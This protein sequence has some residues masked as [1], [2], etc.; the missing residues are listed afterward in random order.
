[1][2]RLDEMTPEEAGRAVG[3]FLKWRRGSAKDKK[4]HFCKG[5]RMFLNTVFRE[6]LFHPNP[7]EASF[8]LQ[9]LPGRYFLGST[10]ITI[11]SLSG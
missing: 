8:P 3:E 10:A 1:M 11:F 6:F 2:G 4:G 7:A 9:G 5:L